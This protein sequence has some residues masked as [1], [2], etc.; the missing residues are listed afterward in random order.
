MAVESPQW[1]RWKNKVR[2]E[3]IAIWVGPPAMEEFIC[4]CKDIL[5]PKGAYCIY[6]ATEP[7]DAEWWAYSHV[8]EWWAYNH[9]SLLRIPPLYSIRTK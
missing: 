1:E 7:G 3:D 6:Y 4:A 9:V 8:D 2:N 5:R